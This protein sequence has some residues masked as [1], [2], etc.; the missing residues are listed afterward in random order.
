VWLLALL[1]VLVAAGGT[2]AYVTRHHDDSAAT[3]KADMMADVSKLSP[4]EYDHLI[5]HPDIVYNLTIEHNKLVSGPSK[6]TVKQGQ[7]VNVDFA[8][9]GEEVNIKLDGYDIITETNGEPGASGG[10]HFVADKTGTFKFYIPAE[11]EAQGV[12]EPEENIPLGT[13]EVK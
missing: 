2:A 9:V 4:D 10:F 7:S 11:H 6:I 13:I 3:T 8:T 12:D 5:T 1:V